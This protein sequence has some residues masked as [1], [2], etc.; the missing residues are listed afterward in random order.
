MG[1]GQKRCQDRKSHCYCGEEKFQMLQCLDMSGSSKCPRAVSHGFQK[2]CVHYV[3]Y[4]LCLS[5]NERPCIIFI[6]LKQ[7]LS[8]LSV[9]LTYVGIVRFK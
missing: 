3:V 4:S 9:S 7:S 2:V 1:G 8:F 6:D 5:L